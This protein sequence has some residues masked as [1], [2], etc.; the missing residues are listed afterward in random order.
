MVVVPVER[1]LLI[2]VIT[3]QLLFEGRV[4]EHLVCL[5]KTEARRSVG[6][7]IIMSQI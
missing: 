3:G 1:L 5:V 7:G 2:V 6:V 4:K